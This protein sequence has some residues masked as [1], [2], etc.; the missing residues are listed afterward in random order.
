MRAF[1]NLLAR[2]FMQ[3]VLLQIKCKSCKI[4]NRVI[5][6][7]KKST[8]PKCGKCGEELFEKFAVVFGYVYILSNP[9]MPNLLKIGQTSGS[10]QRR[11]D[12][13]SAA[14]GV[15]RP[16]IIEACF[17]SQNPSGDEKKLHKLLESYRRPGREFF[18]IELSKALT[19]F[20][21]ILQKRPHYARK[22]H[23]S[24]NDI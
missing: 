10:L 12:Q 1:V 8:H 21:D 19:C 11:V 18:E 2:L 7:D 23:G 5:V 3:A 16:F 14:T 24:F 20:Q 9:D 17:L 6:S 15:S 4:E 13:L 22:I